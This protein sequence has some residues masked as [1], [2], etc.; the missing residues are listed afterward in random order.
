MNDETN[1]GEEQ[2]NPGQQ[3]PR[4]QHYQFHE[5]SRTALTT[6]D[7]SDNKKNRNSFRKKAGTTI[8]LAVIFGLVASVVF[9]TANFTADR[10]FDAGKSD[11][12]ICLQQQTV[13]MRLRQLL[14]RTEM[15]QQ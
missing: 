12:Q 5:E 2:K 15:W 7:P 4:Y 13:Q 8:A 3:P 1:W 6:P 9:Q 11:V 10:L 14:L